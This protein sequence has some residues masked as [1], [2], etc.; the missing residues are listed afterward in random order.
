MDNTMSAYKMET[1]AILSSWENEKDAASYHGEP[2]ITLR[3]S[4][5]R[6]MLLLKPRSKDFNK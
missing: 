1:M 6:P 4:F 2:S 3:N 5:E